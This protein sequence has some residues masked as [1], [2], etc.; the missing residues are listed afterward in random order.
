MSLDNV[1]TITQIF[2]VIHTVLFYPILKYAFI[3]EK[4]LTA[5]ETILDLKEKFKCSVKD[6][7]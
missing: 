7:N 5:I 2:L 1:N 3:L 4:R 6:K